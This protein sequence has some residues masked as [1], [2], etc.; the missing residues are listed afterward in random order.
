MT[1][2]SRNKIALNAFSSAIQVIIVGLVYFFIYRIIVVKLGVD[3]VG[4]WSL[5]LATTSITSLANFGFSS[6]LVKFV[7]EANA[8]KDEEK[9][10]K[11][12][13]T[14][15]FS[16]ITIFF[17]VSLIVYLLAYLFI[18]EVVGPE[19]LNIARRI[20]PFSLLS[21]Y[22]GALGGVWISALEGFQKN[23]I[24]SIIFSSGSILYLIMTMVLVPGN[25]LNGLAYAQVFQSF[26]VFILSFYFLK[27]RCTSFRIFK[28]QWDNNIF[29]LLFGYGY[30]V[31][32]VSLC[33]MLI[34]PLTKIMI[35]RFSGITTLGFYEMASRLI[36]Q[37]RYVIVNMNQVTIPIVSHYSQTDVSAIRYIYERGL[38]FIAFLVFP[39]FAGII[40]F[41]PY[42]SG[43]WIGHIEPVFINCVYILAIS[44]LINIM[45]SPAY[46]NSLGEG[47][48]NGVLIMNFIILALNAMLGIIFGKTIEIYGVILAFGI[49]Y[50]AGSVYLILHYENKKHYNFLNAFKSGDYILIAGT[51]LFSF[52]SKFMLLGI[53]ERKNYS[54]GSLLIL[55]SIY[56]V[57]F[58]GIASPNRNF[59]LLKVTQFFK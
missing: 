31:Q 59:K 36:T 52:F 21:L 28:W 26:F 33:Q 25:G 5:I 43:I 44:M 40:L 29:R 57:F 54:T 32:I 53:S 49:S 34:D 4:V 56:T 46:F 1:E 2:N 13:F 42:L 50:A 30:K 48:L 15:L 22:I 19:Y 47:K 9:I 17:V 12:L 8:R 35:T 20:L 38:S 51:I 14:S 6:A 3:Q 16:M 18:D 45:A 41:T 27:R 39:M 23:Y 11:L 55:F 37:L 10:D 7:A 58:L 24:R